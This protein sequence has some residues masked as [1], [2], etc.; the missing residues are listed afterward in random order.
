M[1][2]RYT[3]FQFQQF[4]LAHQQSA[5]KIGTDAIVLASWLNGAMARQILDFGSGCGVLSFISAQRFPSAQI[6]GIEI[7]EAS[8]LESVANKVQ[9]PFSYR[10]NFL[11]RDIQDFEP[12]AKFDL[13]VSNPPYF[14][15]GIKAPQANRAQAR[16]SEAATF[17]TWMSA[18][19]KMLSP[20][21][22]LALILPPDLW[23]TGAESFQK[24]GL[25]PTRLCRMQHHA[26]SPVKRVLVEL[27]FVASA[28]PKEEKLTLYQDP[29]SLERSREFQALV[30]GILST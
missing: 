5:H 27:S 6:L 17:W 13:I 29:G 19:S 22:K 2:K 30:E 1:A 14:T 8:Y 18:L 12:T 7:D 26:E 28:S 15:E 24:L 23:D 25:F 3:P 20:D 4:A 10:V 21:G 9:N 16:H 11:H